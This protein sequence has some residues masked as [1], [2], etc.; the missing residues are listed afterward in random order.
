MKSNQQEKEEEIFLD[1]TNDEI[2]YIELE[3]G[4]KNNGKNCSKKNC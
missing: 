4:E 2:I 3:G 1:I